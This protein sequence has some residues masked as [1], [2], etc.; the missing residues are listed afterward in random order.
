MQEVSQKIQ[1][2]INGRSWADWAKE[3][4]PCYYEF[5]DDNNIK[6]KVEITDFIKDAIDCGAMRMIKGVDGK[7]SPMVTVQ[8][9]PQWESDWRGMV[10][11]IKGADGSLQSINKYIPLKFYQ[12]NEKIKEN[13]VQ[14]VAKE[15]DW[16]GILSKES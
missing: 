14:E 3:Y 11:R 7:Y 9:N 15:K 13:K 8:K 16:A 5:M 10:K 1:G 2:N 4:K 6:Q 12:Y